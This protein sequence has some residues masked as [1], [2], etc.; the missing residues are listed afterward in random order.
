MSIDFKELLQ[1]VEDRERGFV[2]EFHK[3]LS[4]KNGCKCDI[5]ESKSGYVVSYLRDK[6]TPMNYVQCKT[7]TKVRIYAANVGKYQELLNTLL[8]KL[9]ADIIKAAPC[10][11]LLDPSACNPKCQMGYTFEMDGE[12]YKKCRSTAFMFAL[13]EK[14]DPFIKKFLEKELEV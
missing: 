7:G 8:P 12:V 13:S 1:S 11:L 4:R 14:N 3:F 9:K 6:T 5:K 10:K 2:E